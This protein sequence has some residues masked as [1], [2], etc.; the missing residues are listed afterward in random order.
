MS[1]RIVLDE[2]KRKDLQEGPWRSERFG[3]ADPKQYLR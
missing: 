2:L 1:Q 3:S